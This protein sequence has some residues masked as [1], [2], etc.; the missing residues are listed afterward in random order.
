MRTR[1]RVSRLAAGCL[2]L[3]AALAGWACAAPRN[4]PALD[5]NDLETV[6]VGEPADSILRPEEDVQEQRAPEVALR[7]R[8]P[9]AFPDD[10]PVPDASTVFDFG[11]VTADE[12][13]PAGAE[14]VGLLL[15]L[16]AP[17]AREWLLREA[18]AVGWRAT[19]GD[20]TT[21]R[22]GEEWVEVTLEPGASPG[23]SRARFEYPKP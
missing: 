7:G 18:Q 8:L 11:D 1:T 12:G 6:A 16:G 10:F 13:E 4:P 22:R 21:F 15:P 3:A 2:A 20:S 5:E 23:N 19:L 9:G 14:F 17:A